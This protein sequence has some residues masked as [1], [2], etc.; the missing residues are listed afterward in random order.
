QQDR[1][2]E[3]QARAPDGRDGGDDDERV[4]P[5]EQQLPERRRLDERRERDERKERREEPE[6]AAEEDP[7]ERDPRARYS[8]ACSK[9]RHA[10]PA[11]G[12]RPATSTVRP[13]SPAP[14]CTLPAPGR[15]SR[16]SRAGPGPGP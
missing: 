13:R 2:Q 15:P 6:A 16:S 10:R 9:D 12:T 4:E 3:G 7:R 1:D 11:S 8:P 5:A 14:R